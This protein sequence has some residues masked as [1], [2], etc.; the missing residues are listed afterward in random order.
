[1]FRRSLKLSQP[2][3]LIT[4]AN[5]QL[6]PEMASCLRQRYGKENVI[7]TSRKTDSS[8]SWVAEGPYE[9]LD[10]TDYEAFLRVAKKYE[11][12]WI[13]HFAAMLS[14]VS[15]KNPVASVQVH[16]GDSV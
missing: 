11:V 6:G 2:R 4:G 1:M 15:E 7:C 12:S 16:A 5:G 3:I 9:K 14:A 10:V 13:I 8:F